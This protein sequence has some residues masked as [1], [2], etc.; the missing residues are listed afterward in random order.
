MKAD[1]GRIESRVAAVVLGGLA[2]S[3]TLWWVALFESQAIR[4]AFVTAGDWA[5]L[6]SFLVADCCLAVITGYA[7][8][9]SGR[10]RRSPVIAGMTWGAWIYATAWTCSAA[11]TSTV[12]PLGASLMLL[13][14]LLAGI[15]SRGLV[16]SRRAG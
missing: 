9:V 4:D 11:L 3:V 14:L 12:R 5:T 10:R 16:S 1:P 15:A 6:R 13:G 8:L 7:A 2:L